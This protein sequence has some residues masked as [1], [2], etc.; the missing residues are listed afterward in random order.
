MKNIIKIEN[1]SYRKEDNIILDSI[2]LKINRGEL[3]SII[4]P[5]GS[6]KTSLINILLNRVKCN[7]GKVS[8]SENSIIKVISE[9]SSSVFVT[10]RV[11]DE[12][13]FCLKKLKLSDDEING[14]LDFIVN[15]FHINDILECI[16]SSL[17]DGEKI[18]VSL[19]CILVTYP[20]ILIVDEVFDMVDEITKDNI[21][22]LLKKLKKEKNMTVI[23]ITQNP[24]DILYTER[25]ILLSGGK[26]LLDEKVKNAFEDEKLYK[27]ASISF[28]FM[29]DLCKKLEYYDLIDKPEFNMNKLVNK[30]WK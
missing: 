25:I 3:V 5:S 12:I 16:P 11:I 9:F 30:L 26:V 4:G 17:S 24:N 14:R 15:A 21:F 22:S 18:I 23:F 1:V 8:L 7:D 10:N 29:V 20:D 2:S 13:K 28:P 19:A 27:S 6:G